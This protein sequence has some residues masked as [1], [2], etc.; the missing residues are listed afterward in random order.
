MA[1]AAAVGS[2]DDRIN[3]RIFRRVEL[4]LFPALVFAAIDSLIH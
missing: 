3:V 4:S 1:I 2:L